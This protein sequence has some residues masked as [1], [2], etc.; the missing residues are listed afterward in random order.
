M[1]DLYTILHDRVSI[2]VR[3]E[4]TDRRRYGEKAR[5]KSGEEEREE[6]NKKQREEE[7]KEKQRRE[8]IM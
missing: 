7:K 4:H 1:M 2:P 5:G 6:E 8:K 3:L